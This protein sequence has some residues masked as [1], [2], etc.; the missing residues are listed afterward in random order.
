MRKN[1]AQVYL[2]V[3]LSVTCC[4]LLAAIVAV[5]ASQQGVQ[6]KPTASAT[7]GDSVV[8]RAFAMLPSLGSVAIVDCSFGYGITNAGG[9]NYEFTANVK[10]NTNSAIDSLIFYIRA[11]APNRSVPVGES[12][13]AITIR[14][15][16]EPGE[17]REVTFH[18]SLTDYGNQYY[19]LPPSAPFEVAIVD[20][21]P[22]RYT[23][24]YKHFSSVQMLP[25]TGGYTTPKN[26]HP[27]IDPFFSDI[28][29]AEVPE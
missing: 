23:T 13:D 5:L 29:N 17:T 28:L 3:A 7:S 9:Y 2:I 21:Y 19:P 1:Q 6:K 8:S 14:G 25:V 18:A 27:R 12:L 26:L 11:R 4:V 20:N 22:S 16:I 15:G 24:L 10:N